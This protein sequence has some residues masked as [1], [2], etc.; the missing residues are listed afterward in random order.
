MQR[1]QITGWIVP[2][3]IDGHAMI[4]TNCCGKPECEAC[5]KLARNSVAR[6]V[7]SPTVL[8]G[9][10][11]SR[12]AMAQ[13]LRLDP[14][15]TPTVM[16]N[17]SLD[18]KHLKRK[19]ECLEV[20]NE[21][22]RRRLDTALS[23]LEHVEE[24]DPQAALDRM[25]AVRR[26][27]EHGEILPAEPP[28]LESRGRG[29]GTAEAPV[30]LLDKLIPRG[31]IRRDLLDVTERN[32]ESYLRTNGNKHGFRYPASV[33]HFALDM[34]TKTSVTAY[35]RLTEEGFKLPAY[36]T[37][38]QWKNFLPATEVGVL[39]TVVSAVRH[40]LDAAGVPI[41]SADR[42]VSICTDDCHMVGNIVWNVNSK[43]V[44][45]LATIEDNERIIGA[46]LARAL[47]KDAAAA[48]TAGGGATKVL[49]AKKMAT[50]YNVFLATTLGKRKQSFLVARHF[51]TD[52]TAG[53]NH[54]MWNRSILLLAQ[55]NFGVLWV[56]CDGAGPN[57]AWLSGLATASARDLLGP[58]RTAALQQ[59]YPSVD[60]DPKIAMAHPVFGWECPVFLNNDAPHFF[61][62]ARGNL[63]D[64]GSTNQVDS[65]G[66]PQNSKRV[67]ALRDLK[68][69]KDPDA[70]RKSM[71]PNELWEVLN[72]GMI[73]RPC[74]G[75]DGDLGNWKPRYTEELR[76][77]GGFTLSH[78]QYDRFQAMKV[79]L[80]VKVLSKK[81]LFCIHH[82]GSNGNLKY[83]SRNLPRYEDYG[84][85]TTFIGHWDNMWNVFNS[86][87]GA[88]HAAEDKQL[89][90][91][92]ESLDWHKKWQ[93]DLQRVGPTLGMEPGEIA[94]SYL[95]P[96]TASGM[97]RMCLSVLTAS[98]LYLPGGG[99][100]PG[101]PQLMFKLPALVCR[102]LN[103]DPA[104]NHF[105]ASRNGRSNF[106]VSAATAAGAEST[107]AGRSKFV[108]GKANAFAAPAGQLF[109]PWSRARLQERRAEQA[110]A[111]STT[112]N[113]P[114]I[115]E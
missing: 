107:A 108:S 64:S 24:R 4:S 28:Q 11:T 112:F 2:L 12:Q 77:D 94:A 74:I 69:L 3:G 106:N 18:N 27:D 115:P 20:E 105:A 76:D 40:D 30:P 80:A 56:A 83:H 9:T 71:P 97:E 42:L 87:N 7:G 26:L 33:C 22:L 57:Q 99:V 54:I 88:L 109:R 38:R 85:L 100:A 65:R 114:R 23:E 55:H 49:E 48:A 51:N 21:A 41:D 110:M 98:A 93:S 29:A 35:K 46:E 68:K 104:E 90:P 81:A 101:Y 14:G 111:D 79:G 78:F 47:D 91:M 8:T 58:E 6:R 67:T 39:S 32:L 86:V 16:R 10:P 84:S 17:L 103:Q 72:L 66:I 15:S 73:R 31:T 63:K 1:L 44:V 92:M 43:E 13:S 50:L 19:S 34:L 95:T 62:T 102:R 113:L 60:F 53:L 5:R 61:K 75:I 96:V 36:S 59:L 37:V 82:H 52:S 45:G 89:V 70:A 25:R